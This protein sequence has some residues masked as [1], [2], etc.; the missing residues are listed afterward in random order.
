MIDIPTVD[1]VVNEDVEDR[2]FC[3]CSEYTNTQI[4]RKGRHVL[5]LNGK[6]FLRCA[7]DNSYRTQAWTGAN[8]GTVFLESPTRHSWASGRPSPIDQAATASVQ[9]KL[10]I[11]KEV[12]LVATVCM[13]SQ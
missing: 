2:V 13:F 10:N 3:S 6:T 11:V 12:T 4:A 7:V 5:P 9:V 8:H 1:I